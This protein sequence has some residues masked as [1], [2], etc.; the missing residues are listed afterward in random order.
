MCVVVSRFQGR[1]GNQA[2]RSL[3]EWRCKT[4]G[5]GTIEIER[6]LHVRRLR[7]AF[8]RHYG[9]LNCHN[10]TK[11]WTNFARSLTLEIVQSLVRLL[12]VNFIFCQIEFIKALIQL[13]KYTIFGEKNRPCSQKLIIFLENYMIF[14][15]GSRAIC[16]HLL[17]HFREPIR[18]LSTGAR[19]T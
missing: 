4:G 13:L 1:R 14:F 7:L 10:Y 16:R 3:T 17:K 12:Y 5:F 11:V 2:T 8:S 6:V 18:F 19:G 9:S 15:Q